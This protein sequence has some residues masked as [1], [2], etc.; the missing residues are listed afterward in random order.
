MSGAPIVTVITPTKNRRALLAEA[1]ASV[2]AQTFCDWEHIIVDD[3]SDDGTKEV[4]ERQISCDARIRFI[5]RECKKAGANVCRNIGLKASKS[6]YII[7]LDSDDSLRP[8]CLASRVALMERNLD[9][10]FAVFPAGV[11]THSAGDQGTIYH[12]MKPGDDL[13][14]FLSHECVWEISGPIWHRSFLEILGGFDEDLLS[15]QDLDLHVRALT[16]QGRYVFSST[17]D[18]D[19]RG[20]ED[21]LRTSR[22]HFRNPVYISG[23]SLLRDKLFAEIRQ[24]GLITWSRKRALLGLGFSACE[25]WLS[26]NKPLKAYY[27]WNYECKKLNASLLLFIEGSFLLLMTAMNLPT[28]RLREKWKCLRRLRPEP[29]PADL[30]T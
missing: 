19:I 27:T 18:H 20:H 1:V 21:D 5:S 2:V 8:E 16:A 7:F 13:L 30:L 26:C 24:S 28:K 4:I 9:L 12:P 11:F 10:D 14:R 22:Q 6:K 23:N 15:T 17:V 3:G 25:M 29:V